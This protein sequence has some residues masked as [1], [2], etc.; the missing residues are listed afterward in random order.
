MRRALGALWA[1][2]LAFFMPTAF[3]GDGSPKK[4]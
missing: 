3:H 1:M 4:E 2:V